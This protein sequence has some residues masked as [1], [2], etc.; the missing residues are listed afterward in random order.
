MTTYTAIPNGD[1]DVDSPITTSLMQALRDNPLAIQ[2]GDA[3]APRIEP[4]AISDV[5]VGAY[6]T[7]NF[8]FTGR[9]TVV[10]NNT[11]IDTDTSLNTTTGVFTIPVAGTYEFSVAV[12]AENDTGTAGSFVWRVAIQV[13]NVDLITRDNYVAS[14]GAS[15]TPINI[16]DN[17]SAS[18]EIKVDVQR[19][20]GVGT[21]TLLPNHTATLK[22][23]GD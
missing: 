16:I 2:E 21:A 1:V 20:S 10:F 13:N 23:L 22:Q 9:A 8:G 11:F 17:F 6:S 12:G 19:V 18:D 3:S 7:S 4:K 14:S 15:V 5:S